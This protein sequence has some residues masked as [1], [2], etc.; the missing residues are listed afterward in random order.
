MFNRLIIAA[1]FLCAGI[2]SAQEA[3]SDAT[4]NTTVTMHTSKGAITLELFP[5]QAP[6]TV[7]NFLQYARDGF[8]EGTIFHRVIS[9]FMIQ[10]GGF[11]T[12]MIKKET[13]EAIENEATNGLNNNRGTIAMAR[14]SD[15]HSATAQFFINVQ[16]NSPLDHTGT[17][18]SREWGYVVFGEVTEG[19]DVVDDI[20]FAETAVVNGMRDVP[21]ETIVIERVEISE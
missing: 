7:E 4:T 5:E 13:R 6:A 1:V 17:S 21:V 15:P 8:Y 9:H 19:M 20:R 18:S 10:G 12:E 3:D 2:V 14:T 16:D 11:T